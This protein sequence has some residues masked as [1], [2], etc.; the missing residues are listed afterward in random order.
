MKK[1]YLAAV[2]AVA[3]L[4]GAGVPVVSASAADSPIAHAACK[5]AT[6]GGASK[7]IARGQFCA[8][9]HAADYRRYGLSCTKRDVS[10]R[11]HLA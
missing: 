8:K 5:R 1:R 11:W 10:G 2:V 9:A 7:C 4:A 6:I 3:S